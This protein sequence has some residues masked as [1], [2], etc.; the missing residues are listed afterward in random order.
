MLILIFSAPNEPT[1]QCLQSQK[2][3]EDKE[4]SMMLFLQINHVQVLNEVDRGLRHGLKS[5]LTKSILE[6]RISIPL[7]I[8]PLSRGSSDVTHTTVSD[9][10]WLHAMYDDFNH[11]NAVFNLRTPSRGP[12]LGLG[13]NVRFNLF[14]LHKWFVLPCLESISTQLDWEETRTV[15]SSWL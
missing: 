6:L 10:D 15:F 8:S 11:L 9:N 5:I 7:T 13:L 1:N 12:D 2:M 14:N 3:P 4:W